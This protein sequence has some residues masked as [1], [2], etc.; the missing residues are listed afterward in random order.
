MKT[1]V[2]TEQYKARMV[3][4]RESALSK[5]TPDEKKALSL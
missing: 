2:M 1:Y 3:R 4:L 5:L